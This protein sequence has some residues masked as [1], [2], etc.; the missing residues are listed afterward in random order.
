MD[1]LNM[2]NNS[3]LPC[4]WN[5]ILNYELNTNNTGNRVQIA[6]NFKAIV[7]CLRINEYTGL[8][9]FAAM[10]VADY[11]AD[12]CNC[13]KL[14]M[15][16]GNVH[17]TSRLLLPFAAMSHTPCAVLL[18]SRGPVPHIVLLSSRG[19][20]PLDARRGRATAVRRPGRGHDERRL[21]LLHLQCQHGRH[22]HALDGVLRAFAQQ[23]LPPPG[24]LLIQ[25]GRRSA[26]TPCEQ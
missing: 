16:A 9:S 1:Q 22:Q 7:E 21:R 26:T 10:H 25:T 11:T 14:Y 13:V 5:A 2:L 24:L 17:C 4:E 15:C 20:V 3:S 19:P 6:C 12:V 8:P 18:S 23:D